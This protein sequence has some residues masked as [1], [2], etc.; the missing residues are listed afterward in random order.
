[1][2][3]AILITH[4]TPQSYYNIMELYY[5]NLAKTCKKAKISAGYCRWSPSKLYKTCYVEY[6]ECYCDPFCVHFNDCC[7]DVKYEDVKGTKYFHRKEHMT[8]CC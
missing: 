1:M 7:E 6:S 4:S 2:I 5:V 3:N 8:L